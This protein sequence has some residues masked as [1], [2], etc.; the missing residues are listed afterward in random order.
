MKNMKLIEKP[1]VFEIVKD[2]T[3]VPLHVRKLTIKQIAKV[4][5]LIADK[6]RDERRNEFM[7]I[8]A[9]IDDH[10]ERNDFLAYAARNNMA[11]TQDESEAI[12]NTMF[13]VFTV[14]SLATDLTYDEV[15][16][17]STVDN[18][19]ELDFARYYA[20]GL[21]IDAIKEAMKAAGVDYNMTEGGGTTNTPATFPEDPAE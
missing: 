8:A 18:E 19:V 16:A 9:L 10:K 3:I 6:I 12:A 15:E 14:L 13:G 21:D 20:L 5:D 11:V 4:G 2:G 7:K 17:I 1:R